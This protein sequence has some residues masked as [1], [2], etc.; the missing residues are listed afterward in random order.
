MSWGRAGWLLLLL[1]AGGPALVGVEP[2]IAEVVW[3]AAGEDPSSPLAVDA[4]R[5]S[6]QVAPWRPEWSAQQARVREVARVR[7]AALAHDRGG[8]RR[9]AVP[10][11]R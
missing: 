4:A 3:K 5:L 10:D 9:A 6:A 8:R 1:A 2:E 7:R 11:D